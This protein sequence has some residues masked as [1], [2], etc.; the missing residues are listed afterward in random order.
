[1]IF[2]AHDQA[3]NEEDSSDTGASY[4]D[5]PMLGFSSSSLP[6]SLCSASSSL[7][8]QSSPPPLP[9][10]EEVHQVVELQRRISQTYPS[11][12]EGGS[13]LSKEALWVLSNTSM[14]LLNLKKLHDHSTLVSPLYEQLEA[15]RDMIPPFHTQVGES[16]SPC[17]IT[18][19]LEYLENLRINIQSLHE[20]MQEPSNLYE[21][22]ISTE[23]LSRMDP[24]NVDSVKMVSEETVRKLLWRT[25]GKN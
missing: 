16:S 3:L 20:I 23:T 6:S 21:R 12:V 19:A 15:L 11:A 25:I 24:Y 5:H 18:C 4:E 7:A 9:L 2:T 10:G 17:V 22:C 8:A 1:M 13:A 14:S